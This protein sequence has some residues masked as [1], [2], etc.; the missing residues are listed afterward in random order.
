VNRE[1]EGIKMGIE[2]IQVPVGEMEVF[3]YI[4][5]DTD[6]GDGVV[7]DPA[8]EPD[9]ILKIVS[10]RGIELKYIINTHAHSDHTLANEDI[11]KFTGAQIVMHKKDDEFAKDEENIAWNRKLGFEPPTPA[12]ITVEDG[13]ELPLGNYAI[14]FI[15]TPGHTPGS[16]CIL[17]ENNLFTGDT[18]FVGAVG[19]TDIPGGSFET[20]LESIKN[21]ILTLPP[22]TIV[23]PGHD[24]GDSPH[25]TIEEE[26][27]TNPYITDFILAE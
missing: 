5:Y 24:Y 14:R 25:S 2:V 12:D 22:D 13:D 17:I 3:C 9:K 20:L 10:D 26:M 18:L 1:V 7:I 21:K 15:H 4:V 19:R 8:G 11:R 6:V 27:K 23:W 16:C